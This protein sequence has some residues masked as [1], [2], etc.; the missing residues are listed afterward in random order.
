LDKILTK[1]EIAP[2]YFEDTI[3]CMK[4]ASSVAAKANSIAGCPLL[5]VSEICNSKVMVR[6]HLTS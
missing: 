2:S 6:K 4:M 1:R 3:T 5:D